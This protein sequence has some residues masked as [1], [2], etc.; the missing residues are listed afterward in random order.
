MI[1]TVSAAP[2]LRLSNSAVTASAAVGGTAV[3]QALTVFNAGDGTL[4][5]TLSV[6]PAIT[7]LAA[8]VS[9]NLIQLTFHT[10]ILPAGTYTGLVTV[11]DP[12][13]VDSP[14]VVVVTVQVG[15]LQPAPIDRYVAPGTITNIPSGGGLCF[16]TCPSS[17]TTSD[18]G[19]WLSIGVTAAATIFYYDSIRLAPPVGMPDGSYTGSVTFGESRPITVPVTMHVTTLPIVVPSTNQINL[20]LAQDGPAAVHPFVPA[21]SLTNSGMGTM[22]VTGVSGSGTGVSAINYQGLGIVRVDPGSL[23][24]GT[25]TDGMVTMQCNGANC[26]VK[27]PVSLEIIPQAAPLLQYQGALDNASF[28]PTGSP[29]DVMIVK[30]EQLSLQGPAFGAAP[31]PTTLGG[32][33]VLVNGV[34]TPL[35]YSSFGQ[36]AFQARVGTYLGTALVQVI[37]D[38]QSSNTIS[39][40]MAPYAPG[41]VA[42]TDTAYNIV[43]AT[44]PIKAGSTLVL[45]AI[46]L[47]ATTPA[48]PDG[49]AA[50]ATTLAKVNASVT[51]EFGVQWFQYAAT[52]TF[53]GLSPGTV[54]LYQVNTVVPASAA[55]STVLAWLQLAAGEKSNSASIAVQ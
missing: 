36:I 33:S 34:A 18:G 46:G 15:A 16:S 4:S 51:V 31:L 13:A 22:Q 40:K 7:W 27:I 37:R 29:G 28:S 35:Y 52:P 17:V 55:G 41:I 3:G 45:W 24:P 54:G 44:H 49:E 5:L 43:D 9:G 53:A 20:R 23:A 50:G 47:G 19:N 39:V 42:V 32:S 1:G 6:Q 25:Y 48:V 12:N 26:P 21:I 8:S 10:A 30:G 11:S 38:G 14:Q 2:M